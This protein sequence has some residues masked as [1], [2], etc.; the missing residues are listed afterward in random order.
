MTA[1]AGHH[2]LVDRLA[3]TIQSRVLSGEIA[4]GTRLRQESLASEF[5]VSRTPV[6]E[7][8]HRLQQDGIIERG[9]RG[10]EVVAPSA[11]QI[12]E[13]YEVRVVLEAAA[14]EAAARRRTEVDLVRLRGV[15][16]SSPKAKGAT[17]EALTLANSQF[18][19]AVWQASHNGTLIDL[20]ERLHVHLR[21][22]PSTTLTYPGR[23]DEA[24]GEHAAL[25]AAID[26][27]DARK[28]ARIGRE[29]MTKARDV[30]LRM[31]R[32]QQSTDGVGLT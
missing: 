16:E 7:A 21:R 15:L 30:R 10:L 18:H 24:L 29:H 4:T 20:L 25:V 26:A 23:W 6:R 19:E 11:E 5:G 9:E 8:L 1:T 28:A 27:G 3:A 13:I 17:A 2:G 12:L 14:C 22:Y 32:D 31:W